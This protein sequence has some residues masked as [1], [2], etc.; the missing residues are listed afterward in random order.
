MGDRIPDH[1]AWNA[2]L[3]DELGERLR[4]VEKPWCIVGG[5]ALDLWHGRPTRSHDDLEFTVLREDVPAF[6][7]AL[8]G[9]E[10]FTAH[11]GVVEPLPDGEAPPPHVFQ[12]WALDV[13]EQRWRVDMM[14]EPG[15]PQDWIYRRDPTITRPRAKMV[16][17]TP[18]GLP[19]LK[20]AAILLF[21]AKHMRA[22]DEID[23]ATA[24]PR[25]PAA[26]R[27]WLEECL[28]RTHPGHPWIAAL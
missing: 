26:E 27:G 3:P 22:K 19:Y 14:I 15:T 24:L 21:K 9:L 11:D 13:Q 20:P 18:D 17:T 7:A 12:I 4:A 2:W 6:R 25:L 1:D 28:A 8:A 10:F 16:E 23:F 5:W